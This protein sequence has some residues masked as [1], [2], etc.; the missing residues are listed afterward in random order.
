[1]IIMGR[2]RFARAGVRL[3][4][5]AA[6]ARMV[7]SGCHEAATEYTDNTDLPIKAGSRDSQKET[8]TLVRVFRVIRGRLPAAAGHGRKL[9]A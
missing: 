1:M 4:A 5:F 8:S 2:I 6:E 9:A 7:T 3:Q